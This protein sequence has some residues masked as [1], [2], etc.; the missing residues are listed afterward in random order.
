MTPLFISFHTGGQYERHA[1][2]LSETLTTFNLPHEIEHMPCTGRWSSN[3]AMK[4]QFILSKMDAWPFRPLVWLDADAR[5]RKY[6]EMLMSMSATTD[7]AAHWLDKVELLSG[8]LYFGGTVAS[9]DLVQDWK[10]RCTAQ[11]NVW[12]QRH[13][14]ESVNQMPELNVVYLP[15]GYTR[16]FDR[17]K[18]IDPN[19]IYVEHLQASRT[20]ENR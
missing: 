16:I 7:F 5:V 9:V 20:A 10:K 1:A 14:S 11:P 12:D 2:E 13:L 6:P 19:E 4:A 15:E 17:H 18:R 3:C 8:T